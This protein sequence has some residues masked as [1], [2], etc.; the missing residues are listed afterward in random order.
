MPARPRG[1]ARN[2]QPRAPWQL[3][4]H[5]SQRRPFDDLDAGA[6]GVG[7]VRDGAAVWN[8]AR[9]LVELDAFRLDLPDKGGVILHVET[10]VVEH[11]SSGRRLLG[12]GLGEPD[13]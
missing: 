4:H 7:D 6:P 9:R 13:L 5:R 2:A 8:L 1:D 10:D 12:V 11:A 3:L